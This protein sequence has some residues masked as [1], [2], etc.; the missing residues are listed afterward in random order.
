M[1]PRLLTG[2]MSI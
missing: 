1:R 2:F